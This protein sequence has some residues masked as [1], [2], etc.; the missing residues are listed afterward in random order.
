MG[1]MTVAALITSLQR[2]PADLSIYLLDYE[3]Y[4]PDIPLRADDVPSIVPP[5]EKHALPKRV[6]IGKG[7]L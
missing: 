1:T 2:S 6:V 7:T 4:V 5:E 3:E